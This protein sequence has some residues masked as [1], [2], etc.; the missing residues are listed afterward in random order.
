M[1]GGVGPAAADRG[2][3]AGLTDVDGVTRRRAVALACVADVRDEASAAALLDQVLDLRGLAEAV[4]RRTARW[5]RQLYP[6]SP[7]HWTESLEPDLLAERHV[8]DE[9]AACPELASGCVSAPSP[10]QPQRALTVL[11]RAMQH[12]DQAGPVLERLIGEHPELSAG[13]I[14]VFFAALR[15][16]RYSVQ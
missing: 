1:R 3:V 10:G 5:L 4:R 7:P 8:A 14:V 13:L 9:F 2:E 11:A 15:L 12:H 6:A 16:Y